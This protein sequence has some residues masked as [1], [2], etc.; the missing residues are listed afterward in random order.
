MIDEDVHELER[1]WRETGAVDDEAAWLRARVRTGA[2]SHDCLRLAVWLGHPAAAAALA[3]ELEVPSE[4]D[5]WVRGLEMW[6]PELVIIA[7]AA[8]AL[9]CESPPA[10]GLAAW[11]WRRLTGAESTEIV[12]FES[13]RGELEG[14]LARAWQRLNGEQPLA[15]NEP[16]TVS[17][18]PRDNKVL[19][20]ALMRRVQDWRYLP[21]DHPE[22]QSAWT[23]LL[24]RFTYFDRSAWR[25][26]HAEQTDS[27]WRHGFRLE[28]PDRERRHYVEATSGW[29]PGP[30][31]GRSS[32]PGRVGIVG[33]VIVSIA[34]N[35]RA[36]TAIRNALLPW[37][38]GLD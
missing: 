11:A 27:G 24:E 6:H 32:L 33:D 10:E 18:G 35:E 15:P 13:G 29:E 38:L 5:E 1:R 20:L 9:A 14:V 28:R 12:E 3:D 7:L 26:N 25:Y 2:L 22:V 31:E 30:D 17:I 21:D 36:R 16:E 23:R 4:L 37:A 19:K 8:A 34:D